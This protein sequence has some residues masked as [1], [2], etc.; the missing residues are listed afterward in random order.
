MKLMQF[1]FNL[2]RRRLHRTAAEDPKEK[3]T[4]FLFFGGQQPAVSKVEALPGGS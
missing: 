2:R 1:R 4:S 3:A